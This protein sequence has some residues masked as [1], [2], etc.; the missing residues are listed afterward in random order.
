MIKI[1]V[2]TYP[3]PDVWCEAP[4]LYLH[5]RNTFYWLDNC[6]NKVK[7]FLVRCPVLPDFTFYTTL[8]WFIVKTISMFTAVF[9]MQ[10]VQLSKTTLCC[11]FYVC[12]PLD[13]IL[14][15]QRDKIYFP[16]HFRWQMETTHSKQKQK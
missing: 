5:W 4:D 8:L 11:E 2:L 10:I 15:D 1:T 6:M 13:Y 7:V 9:L 14:M 12:K 3:G 16:R